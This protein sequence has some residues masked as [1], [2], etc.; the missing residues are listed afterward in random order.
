MSQEVLLNGEQHENERPLTEY[1]QRQQQAM[2]VVYDLDDL[3]IFGSMV[4]KL[5][6]GDVQ[7][8]QASTA[9]GRHISSDRGC[10]SGSLALDFMLRGG[11]PN[12]R[13]HM[14]Y[15]PSMAGK[16]TLS[17]RIMAMAQAF[18]RPVL[19][20]DAEYAAD[21]RYMKALGLDM[22]RP[23]YKY[24]QPTTGDGAFRM[25][26]NV[27]S[28]WYDKYG[29]EGKGCSKPGPVIVIDSLKALTPEAF[30]NNDEKNPIAL[31][32]R[33][34]SLWIPAIKA[35][36]GK[37]NAVLIGINQ[38]RQNPG[39]MFGNPETIPGGEALVFFADSIL[40]LSRV[41]KAE[42]TS[43]GVSMTMRI[44]MK[45]MKH[46]NPGTVFDLQLVQGIGFDPTIDIWRMMELAG[47]G[48]GSRGWYTIRR[49]EGMPDLPTGLEYDKKYRFEE[50]AVYML[51]SQGEH[52]TSAPLYKWCF[53]LIQTGVIFDCIKV[54]EEEQKASGVIQDIGSTLTDFDFSV[55]LK[56]DD[57]NMKALENAKESDALR[58]SFR[59]DEFLPDEIEKRFVGQIVSCDI[60]E[61][62][63]YSCRLERLLR[64]AAEDGVW[65]AEIT[66]TEESEP[67][68]ENVDLGFVVYDEKKHGKL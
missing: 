27:L 34:F 26:K 42:E 14:I 36:V 54:W 17:S 25:I 2:Q 64:P 32:A 40:R 47:I 3:D 5:A 48:E 58:T 6:G 10:A 59:M 33:M 8:I 50:L 61:N 67:Y 53:F 20:I 46:V 66:W 60:W 43:W 63:A 35:L 45:K 11:F 9:F 55:L 7:I 21:I 29:V 24:A 56:R 30:M 12:G 37:T 22:N 23:G 38:V 62:T 49:Y 39:A 16:T 57:P 44:N 51:P 28:Q 1:E 18:N 19:H 4:N 15:G 68:S 65:K 41:G 52:F 31:Q 13:F